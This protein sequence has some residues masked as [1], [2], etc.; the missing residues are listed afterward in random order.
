M[1]LRM[2]HIKHEI[3]KASP[4][5]DFS[6][7]RMREIFLKLK[8]LKKGKKDRKAWEFLKKEITPLRSELK[9]NVFSI[10]QMEYKNKN[11]VFHFWLDD[12]DKKFSLA[13]KKDEKPK[14]YLNNR[15]SGF[16]E[17]WTKYREELKTE[18]A[19]IKK[20]QEDSRECLGFT[21]KTQGGVFN[22]KNSIVALQTIENQMTRIRKSKKPSPTQTDK[23]VG[24]ELELLA[25]VNR[26]RLNQV[27]CENFLAGYVYVKDDGSITKESVTDF[28]HEITVLC[29]ETDVNMVITRLCNVLNGK[30]VQAFVNNSC[31]LHVHIDCR[32]RKEKKVYNNLVKILPMLKKMVP[33][34]RTESEHANRY[35]KMNKTSEFMS[36]GGDRYYAVNGPDAFSKY[37]TI[38]VRFHSGTT[39]AA[40]I[41]NWIKILCLAGNAEETF[42]DEIETAVQFAAKTSCSSTI[43][44]YIVKRTERFTGKMADAL[45][46][47]ADH[48]F[49]EQ[50][51]IAV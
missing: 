14:D 2:A 51:E 12:Y 1:L 42:M 43:V 7:A 49:E 33:K 44:E 47:R 18:R 48:F 6:S 20:V 10:F 5:A 35:C 46:T 8:T 36:A 50:N 41:I 13:R 38:E 21:Y 23:F 3:A 17:S 11:Y 26:D 45:D 24:V 32:N 27:L 16:K 25:K 40:K 39:N 28:P 31:G 34:S 19:N 15:Y 4:E 30:E 29:K 37:K 22:K 9:D